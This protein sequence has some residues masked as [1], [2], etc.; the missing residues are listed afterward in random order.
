[1][2]LRDYRETLAYDVAFWQQGLD[3]P[4]YPLDQLGRLSLDVSGKFRAL[5]IIVLLVKSNADLFFHNLI[6]SANARLR[7]LQRLRDAGI[8]TDH[9]QASGRV[10]AVIDAIA[11]ND[12]ERARAI[13]ALSLTDFHAG[14]EWVDD[15][16]WAQL[17]HGLIPQTPAV[18]D[19]AALLEQFALYQGSDPSGRLEIARALHANDQD[20]FDEAFEGLLLERELQIKEAVEDGQLEQPETM[21]NRRVFV[22][23]LAILRLAETRGLKTQA[24]YRFCPSLARVPMR[25]P[26]PGE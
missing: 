16:C 21:A 26:F 1:M 8:R 9:H 12:F 4:D 11:A 2:R 24:E 3:N 7:Y 22:E 19:S 15:Y 25:E 14:H 10:D 23:G 18:I 5:G 20:Q 17:V 6:R 13:V